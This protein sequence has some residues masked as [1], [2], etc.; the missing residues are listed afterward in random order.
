[1]NLELLSR[2]PHHWLIF[3]LGRNAWI[4]CSHILNTPITSWCT[5]QLQSRSALC[6]ISP[7]KSLNL[8]GLL[9]YFALI[10]LTFQSLTYTVHTGIKCMFSGIYFRLKV[11][12]LY[13]LQ[14]NKMVCTSM[15]RV[16]TGI[17]FFT[18]FGMAF[19]SFLNG[20]SVHI[21]RSVGYILRVPDYFAGLQGPAGLPAGDSGTA[22][23]AC[24]EPKHTTS[25]LLNAAWHP[26]QCLPVHEFTTG[27]L[28]WLAGGCSCCWSAL[29]DS[30]SSSCRDDDQWPAH[31]QPHW[32]PL[33]AM[34]CAW[35]MGVWR[36][37]A[38]SC[39]VDDEQ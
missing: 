39:G 13:I 16:H 8:A 3:E 11:C 26:C 24:I 14:G 17:W 18:W 20:T 23:G 28:R 37:W 33:L 5:A 38:S 29:H 30:P 12:T 7:I 25:G 6:F 21:M 19:L 27:C 9:E 31:Q 32:Q 10:S 4:I 22:W 2:W 15:Y 36:T 35:R 1:M 34:H